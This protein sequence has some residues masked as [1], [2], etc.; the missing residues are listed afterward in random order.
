MEDCRLH[1]WMIE[2][3]QRTVT[4]RLLL[5]GYRL[6]ILF[7]LLSATNLIVLIAGEPTKVSFSWAMFYVV[8]AA[9]RC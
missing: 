4:H 2:A 7:I 1:F 6:S 8:Q 9:G 3:P 5:I